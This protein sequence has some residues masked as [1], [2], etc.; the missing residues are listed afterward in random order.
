MNIANYKNVNYNISK[1][2]PYYV[3]HLVC[4][5]TGILSPFSPL[6]GRACWRLRSV[7][8]SGK[9]LQ[10]LPFKA[11]SLPWGIQIFIIIGTSLWTEA[12]SHK[13]CLSLLRVLLLCVWS[14]LGPIRGR[15]PQP[16]FQHTARV[17]TWLCFH[18]LEPSCCRWA[19]PCRTF[20]RCPF[21]SKLSYTEGSTHSPAFW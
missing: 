5:L 9:L 13:G 19:C 1:N 3:F 6:Y 8:A 2:L 11:G 20:L 7:W 14:L 21:W 4:I 16:L 18:D 12:F 10:S 17:G 15:L